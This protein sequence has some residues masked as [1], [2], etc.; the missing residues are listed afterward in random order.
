MCDRVMDRQDKVNGHFSQ[1]Y[2]N[3]LKSLYY[4]TKQNGSITYL[5]ENSWQEIN[6]KNKRLETFHSSTC[7]KQI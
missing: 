2:V 1:L 4:N 3:A 5:T 7:M 6:V